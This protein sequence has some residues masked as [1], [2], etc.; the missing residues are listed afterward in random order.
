MPDWLRD[1]GKLRDV[2]LVSAGITYVLGFLVRSAWAFQHNMGLIPGGDAQYLVAGIVP[3]GLIG[4]AWVVVVRV[5]ALLSGVR[6]SRV[7]GPVEA[8][9]KLPKPVGSL[10]FGAF[11]GFITISALV[12]ILTGA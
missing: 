12:I 10:L 1:L 4:V 11:T 9:R 8:Y 2:A 5:D 3:M 6:R 7:Q